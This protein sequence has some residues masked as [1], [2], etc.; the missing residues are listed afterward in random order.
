MPLLFIKAADI[1]FPS[2]R[3][4]PDAVP[5]VARSHAIARPLCPRPLCE[6]VFAGIRRP[7]WGNANLGVGLER[8]LEQPAAAIRA[9]GQS[10]N[11]IEFW[12]GSDP[13]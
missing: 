11:A 10:C 1:V 7:F 6:R 4:V 13:V 5:T 3:L 9:T 2:H 12:W 8:V